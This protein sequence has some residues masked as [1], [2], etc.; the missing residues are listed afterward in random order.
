MIRYFAYGS[1]MPLRRIRARLASAEM[2][3]IARLDG[4]RLAFHKLSLRDRSAKCDIV[5][6]PEASVWGVVYD[7]SKRDK[8][9]LDRFEGVG[10]GYEERQVSVVTQDGQSLSTMT[11][12]ATL[13][14]PQRRPY[15]WYKTHVL[16]GAMEAGFPEDYIRRIERVPAVPDPDPRREASELAIY[17]SG[18][19]LCPQQS[20]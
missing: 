1:N 4:Y 15:T 13:I 19:D 20:D 2:V 10:G 5:A 11:Y 16:H 18:A 8:R 9:L 14:D 6:S 12:Y 3:G 17:E 7:I